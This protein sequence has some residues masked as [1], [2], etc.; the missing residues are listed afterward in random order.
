MNQPSLTVETKTSAFKPVRLVLVVFTLLL[1]VSFA[2][3]WY[4]E[5]V[6]MSRYCQQPEVT[7]KRLT[8]VITENRPA[9]DGA[10]RDYIVA[11]KLEFLLP[12][13]TDE[14]LEAYLLR[15]HRHLGEHC[16]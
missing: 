2:A 15:L 9:G 13:G 7:L 1:L 3:H 4:A 16:G 14:P 10:R 6:S 12:R 11:A 5:Q 8:A